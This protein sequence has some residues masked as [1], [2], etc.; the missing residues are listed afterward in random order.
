VERE[1]TERGDQNWGLQGEVGT[2][3]N[4]NSLEPTRWTLVRTPINGGYRA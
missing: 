2:Q 4:G 3:D 1:N